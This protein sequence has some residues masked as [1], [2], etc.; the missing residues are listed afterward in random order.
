MSCDKTTLRA[1]EEQIINH[2]E[3]L[4]FIKEWSEYFLVKKQEVNKFMLEFNKFIYDN[5][6]S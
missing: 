2:V 3:S 1:R 4:G 5:N 6:W